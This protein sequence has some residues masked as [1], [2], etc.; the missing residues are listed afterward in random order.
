MA[1]TARDKANCSWRE[2]KQRQRVYQRLV[3]Q[4]RMTP[5]LAAKE[6]RLM[7]AIARDY[8]LIADNEEKAGRLI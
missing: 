1:D 7:E 2:V 8:D 5:Q 4:G 6:L 3:D